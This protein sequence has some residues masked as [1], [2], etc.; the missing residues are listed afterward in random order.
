[1]GKR[2]GGDLE[3][4]KV[5][6]MKFYPITVLVSMV[7]LVLGCDTKGAPIVP[8][9]RVEGASVE[10]GVSPGVLY[11]R[12][13]LDRTTTVEVSVDYA[14]SDGTAKAG[15]DY[16]DSRGTVTLEPGAAGADIAV[17]I[18]GD[19]DHIRGEDLDF[20][21]HLSNAR[22]G[23]I[24]IPS[25]TGIIIRAN[26]STFITDTMGYRSPVNYP[27]LQLVWQDEFDGE[28]LS[29]RDWNY[30][31]GNGASGWGNNELEFYTDS[32]KNVFLSNGHLIIEARKEPTGG[33]DYTS[34]RITTQGK[35]EFQFGRVDIRAKLPKGQGIWPALW[36]LGSNFSTIGW[37]VCGEIDIMEM[38]GHE[39]YKVHAAI[40]Y[41][42][43]GHASRT[44]SYSLSGG[45]TF[46]DEF[47]VFSLVWQEGFLQILVDDEVEMEVSK[48]QLGDDYPFNAPF[49]FI[50]NVAVGGNWPGSP[51]ASTQFPQR[52]I[53]DYIRVFQ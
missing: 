23:N 49:F 7:F 53:V 34:A 20:T 2:L 38:L 11:F 21:V 8:N 48:S 3:N 12:V 19:P 50:M 30:E 27:N 32:P 17:P 26:G 36:M 28:K 18:L 40:H 39:P 42:K 45:S 16:T 43:N 6:H 52:M 25:A 41:G 14:L 22:N 33:F 29:D 13:M 9:I 4:E 5:E 46:N 15:V 1:M 10:R 37:P 44:N 47:H 31:I 24:S 35:Q 51:D